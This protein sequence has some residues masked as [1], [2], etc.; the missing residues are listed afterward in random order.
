MTLYQEVAGDGPAVVLV[1][2][3]IC[4]SRMWDPQ[5]TSFPR[6]HRTVRYD[7]RGFGRS[8]L[9]PGP[10]ADARDLAALLDG[11]GVERAALVAA[12]YGGRVALELAVA[13]PDLVELLVLAGASLPGHDWSPA[14]RDYFAQEE[15]ALERGD[16]DAA[17]E[18]SLRTWVDGSGRPAGAVDPT[19]REAVR[20]MQRRAF[21]LQLPFAD[22]DEEEENLE[23]DWPDRLG[24]VQAPALVLVGDHDQP[25]IHETARRLAGE[26]P[27]ARTATIAGAA[28]LPSMERPAEFDR[29]VLAFLAEHQGR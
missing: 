9:T 4:D 26:L 5:W 22:N 11:L 14:L 29:L 23:P 1:H 18:A 27:Q 3:G 6:D 12:S 15:A 20:R 8:P 24:K 13:R 16:I 10:P 7:L 17:V 28:H 21:E 2:A 25:D 19:V